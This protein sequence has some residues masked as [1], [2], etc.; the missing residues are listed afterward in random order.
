[1][2]RET[3][4]Q[5]R[6]PA[7]AERI[8]LI[9]MWCLLDFPYLLSAGVCLYDG[10]AAAGLLLAALAALV[11]LFGVSSY[12]KERHSYIEINGD[13]IRTVEYIRCSRR[14]SIFKVSQIGEIK[15][16]NAPN[17]RVSLPYI[18]VIDRAGREMFSVYRC[19]ESERVFGELIDLAKE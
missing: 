19:P 8:L 11:G 6:I 9:F 15:N 3:P 4:V 5:Q 16:Y 12:M 1:M 14:E 17:G 7:K 10:Q 2:H 18:R 13:E